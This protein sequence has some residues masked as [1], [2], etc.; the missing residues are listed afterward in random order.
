M[1]VMP[2]AAQRAMPKSSTVT[3]ST[4]SSRRNRL[5][6]LMSRWT[7][8][9]PWATASASATRVSSVTHSEMRSGPRSRRS[10]RSFPDSHSMAR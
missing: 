7:T 2:A 1:S 8:P 10:P 9:R 3:P 6:G 4:R 5:L